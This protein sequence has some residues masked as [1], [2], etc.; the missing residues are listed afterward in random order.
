[1]SPEYLGNLGELVLKT[2]KLFGCGV[3]PLRSFLTCISAG[4]V[5]FFGVVR[6]NAFLLNV[7]GQNALR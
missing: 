2:V 6:I 5:E 4:L 7:F 1:M 3:S